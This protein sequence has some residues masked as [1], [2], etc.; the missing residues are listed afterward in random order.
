MFKP[1]KNKI[2]PEG[3]LDRNDPIQ[4]RMSENILSMKNKI[5]PKKKEENKKI[6]KSNR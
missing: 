5:K 1:K 4:A 3:T 6:K 2:V